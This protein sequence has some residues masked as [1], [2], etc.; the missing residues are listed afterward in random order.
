MLMRG[1]PYS[2]AVKDKDLMDLRIWASSGNVK[3]VRTVLQWDLPD[4]HAER[5]GVGLEVRLLRRL[6]IACAGCSS[7][8]RPRS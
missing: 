7:R 8:W 5:P 4:W 6:V 2:A 1:Y 3:L